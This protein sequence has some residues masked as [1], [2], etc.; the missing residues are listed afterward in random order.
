M[1]SLYPVCAVL[2]CRCVS[3]AH[4]T[5][6]FGYDKIVAVLDDVPQADLRNFLGYCEA[7][8]ISIA[9]HHDC[10]EE[11][12]FPLLN[13]KMDF[14]T[15]KEQH[16]AVH[17]GVEGLL[18]AVNAAKTDPAAFNAAE[19]KELMVAFREPLVRPSHPPLP[20]PVNS[21]APVIASA[22]S[23]SLQY[24]H[25]DDEVEHITADKMR[26]AGFTEAELKNMISKM[27]AYAKSH[28]DPFL[29]VPYMRR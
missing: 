19:L 14:S 18:N 6:K 26:A 15:E 29:Q 24:T 22:S 10:E 4:N 12:V 17:S 27:E 3:L 16:K 1:C 9:E 11:V 13:A 23:H 7:W 21:R 25:L 20:P 5:F 8:A 2:T 28:G